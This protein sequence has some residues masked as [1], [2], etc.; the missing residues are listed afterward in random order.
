MPKKMI[1]MYRYFDEKLYELAGKR[2]TKVEAK[3]L[4]NRL[5]KSGFLVRIVKSGSGYM[6]YGKEKGTGPYEARHERGRK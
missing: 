5:R 3:L 1:N 6:I 4:E 2:P